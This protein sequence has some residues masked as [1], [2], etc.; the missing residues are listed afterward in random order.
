VIW[1]VGAV[2]VDGA[3]EAWA[4]EEIGA[5][6]IGRAFARATQVGQLASVLGIGAATVLGG[7]DLRAPIL[8]GALL[9][10]LLSGLLAAVM[11]ETRRRPVRPV[12]GAVPARIEAQL[13]AMRA[14]LSSGATAVRRTPVLLCLL[15]SAFFVGASSEGFDR[16]GQPHF[17]ADVTFPTAPQPVVW[18]GAFSVAAMLGSIL[19]VGVIRRWMDALN[20]RQLGR[21]LAL[22]QGGGAMGLVVFAFAGQ[23]GIAVGAFILVCLLRSAAAPLLQAWLVA[24]T[25][26]ATRATVFSMVAQVDAAGQIAGGPPIG[27][28]GQGASLRLALAGCGVLSLPAVAFSLAAAVRRGTPVSGTSQVG[29]A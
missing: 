28:L 26:P 22:Y 9:L 8:L 6:Q 16:L 27:L 25:E 23:F 3:Q 21:L 7:L 12:A 19:V 18:F 11:P 1:G 14:Q 24:E 2:C 5:G 13:F 10:L 15:G 4:A 17:L 20:R 29:T